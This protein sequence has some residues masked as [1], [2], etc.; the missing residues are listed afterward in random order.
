MSVD[1]VALVVSTI[2]ELAVTC[3][4]SVSPLTASVMR[5]VTI[6]PDRTS[7]FSNR[8]VTK[9]ESVVVTM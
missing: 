4:C 5:R 9:P 3:T 8:W 1:W 7:T 2:G 6:C